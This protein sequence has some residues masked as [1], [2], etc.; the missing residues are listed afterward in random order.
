V[1]PTRVLLATDASRDAA[2][3][4]RAAVDLSVQ[5]DS[6]LHVV[7]VRRC[8]SSRTHYWYS[9]VENHPLLLH[10]LLARELLE[11]Q[12]ERLESAGAPVGGTH[13]RAGRSIRRDNP[14][15]RRTG[16]RAPDPGQPGARSGC[17]TCPGQRLREGRLLCGPSYPDRAR[18]GTGLATGEG[19][20]RRRLLRAGEESDRS[21]PEHR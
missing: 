10:E 6:E 14:P 20:R 3:A 1:F 12:M 15:G 19:S 8:R 7:H 9:K 5:T 18:R 16:S 4:A 17:T 2:L 13:L 21:G 11:E